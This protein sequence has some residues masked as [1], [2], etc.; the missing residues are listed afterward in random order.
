MDSWWSARASLATALAAALCACGNSDG[1]GAER[2]PAA[3]VPNCQGDC[4]QETAADGAFAD[5]LCTKVAS[6]CLRFYDSSVLTTE[7]QHHATCV[8]SLLRQGF[9]RDASL[10]AA[11]LQEATAAAG[12]DICFPQLVPPNPNAACSRLL[13]EPGGPLRVPQEC[14]A[15][16]DCASKPGLVTSCGAPSGTTP[17]CELWTRGKEGDVCTVTSTE[18]GF[19]GGYATGLESHYCP[20]EEGLVCLPFEM[21]TGPHTCQRPL[22]EGAPCHVAYP[23]ASGTCVAQPNSSEGTCAPLRDPHDLPDGASCSDDGNCRNH[24]CER[25]VCA[26]YVQFA[27]ELMFCGP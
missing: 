1:S 26:P 5:E 19:I 8:R 11:C 3:A 4:W 15:V 12:T 9:S 10:R 13:S 18:V 14:G 20:R 7:S 24:Q 21:T 27:G 2:G 25:G 17:Y 23:C 22:P 16:S 6:C